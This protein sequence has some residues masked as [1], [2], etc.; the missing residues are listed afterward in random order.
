MHPP[1]ISI[2][3]IAHAAG[4]S[5]ST[6]SRALA[7]SSLISAETRE[8]IQ[9]LAEQMGYIPDAVAQSLQTRSTRTVG[10]VVTSIADP[11]FAA[12]V[13][14]AEETAI[15]AG[16]SVFINV[17]HNDPEAELA[18]IETLHRRRV[19]GII[20]AASRLGMRHTQALAR[21]QVPVVMVNRQ[22]DEHDPADFHSIAVDDRG[23]A[24]LA[25]EYLL[26][27]GHRRI[28]YLGMGNRFESNR[29]RLEGYRAALAG[30]GIQPPDAWI[31]TCPAEDASG[32]GDVAA[33]E[34]VFPAL[35]AA[36]VTAVFCYNDQ[37]AVGGLLA[38]RKLRVG[39]PEGC[40]LAGFDDI[41]LAR[42]VEPPLTT[43]HQPRREMGRQA[44][45]MV[46]DL[47]AGKRVENRV[48]SPTLVIRSS[49]GKPG[50]ANC[51]LPLLSAEEKT[52]RFMEMT[53]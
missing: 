27:L 36:G 10:L 49:A 12:I 19:D 50:E 21:V 44:M 30:A 51:P 34:T 5:H 15:A 7:G 46:L 48:L 11:F 25:V 31:Q 26:S 17:S 13:E 20:L 2:K 16:M 35:L 29:S 45:Q 33:A 18:L 41:D 32:R 22:P 39:V 38:C 14:G 6:V 42:Y 23:G 3:D 53:E 40:S 37:A 8:R 47:L 24:R 1:R 4:V 52:F 28:G 43:V 9:A